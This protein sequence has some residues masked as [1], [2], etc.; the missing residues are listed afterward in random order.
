MLAVELL[1]ETLAEVGV[2][3][4]VDERIGGVVYVDEVPVERIV[5]YVAERDEQGGRVH[6]GHDERDDEEHEDRLQVAQQRLRV[7]V[8]GA[9]STRLGRDREL[10]IGV[11]LAGRAILRG[12]VSVAAQATLLVGLEVDA[13]ALLLSIT[14]G[15][16]V[17]QR[18]R[19]HRVSVTTTANTE[20]QIDGEARLA[21]RVAAAATSRRL[22]AAHVDHFEHGALLFRLRERMQRAARR[23]RTIH[24]LAADAAFQRRLVLTGQI[25]VVVIVVVFV[26]S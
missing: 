20:R 9:V 15:V 7:Q 24:S 19:T 4:R 11:R 1:L 13:A 6:D 23:R 16:V 14:G 3:E 12:R 10:A 22:N 25:V 21:S 8:A 17:H 2:E 26:G 5:R 18:R